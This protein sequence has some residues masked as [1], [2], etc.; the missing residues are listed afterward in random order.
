MTTQIIALLCLFSL[1]SA[2]QAELLFSSKQGEVKI[3][4][5]ENPV[6]HFKH[7][8]GTY[9]PTSISMNSL[10]A[11]PVVMFL[12]G[13]SALN[14][15]D[16]PGLQIENGEFTHC[17]AERDPHCSI[18]YGK[19]Q[20]EMYIYKNEDL[21]GIKAIAEKNQFIAILPGSNIGWT[22][23]SVPLFKELKQKAINQI[24]G[25]K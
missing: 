2:A 8:V 13:G 22:N 9:I 4:R 25:G 1:T 17:I 16:V 11:V 19:N 12:H 18:E 5:T 14:R 24:M 23:E 20:I 6:S 10:S 15:N 7:Y 21:D 3:T